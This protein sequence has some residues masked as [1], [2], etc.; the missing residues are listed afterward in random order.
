MAPMNV[1][2]C[3]CNLNTTLPNE[4]LSGEPEGGYSRYT[5]DVDEDASPHFLTTGEGCD[6]SSS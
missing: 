5:A 2:V 3:G 6:D 4:S 1:L